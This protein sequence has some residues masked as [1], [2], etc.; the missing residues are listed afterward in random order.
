MKA[1]VVAV[2]G[3]FAA[4]LAD[5][6]RI[7]KL[8]DKNYAIGQ[9]IEV[10]AHPFHYSVKTAAI[11][12]CV[13]VMLV[14]SS[15]TAWA[16]CSPSSYV[17][18]DVNPSIEYSVNRFSRVIGVEA[19]NNDGEAILQSLHLNNKPIDEAVK[20]TVEE[21][22]AQ[23]YFKDSG[24]IVISAAGEDQQSSQQLAEELRTVAQQA[25]KDS[26]PGVAVEAMGVGLERV[27]EARRLGTTPG[28]LNLVEK[29]QA[30]SGNSN[31]SLSEWL[32]KPVKDIMKAIQTERKTPAPPQSGSTVSADSAAETLSTEG[33][34]ESGEPEKSQPSSASGKN[35]SKVKSGAAVAAGQKKQAAAVPEKQQPK[36]NS[37]SSGAS[38][39]NSGSK[40]S[41]SSSPSSASETVSRASGSQKT[42]SNGNGN[43]GSK[44]KSGKSSNAKKQ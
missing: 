27:Q 19:V 7:T 25:V 37:S 42:S 39:E 12:V 8:R 18:L 32:K 41:S 9:V 36:Q 38:S 14:L 5:D 26:C 29:L 6:G 1:C 31:L 13:A 15:V 4:V 33:P 11:A 35:S 17:S 30:S 44:N 24:G 43:S 16:Y 20:D 40:A 21:I 10:K 22:Q 28:K 2:K 3:G 23:G 34:A